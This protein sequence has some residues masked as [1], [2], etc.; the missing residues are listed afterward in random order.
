MIIVGWTILALAATYH[1][2]VGHWFARVV[3]FVALWPVALLL[4]D[5]EASLWMLPVW[6]AAAWAVASLPVWI[7]G[8]T[9]RADYSAVRLEV[10]TFPT[11]G[12]RR[13]R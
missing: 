6:L 4:A 3:M 8:L 5:A 7:K 13:V 11:L 9:T 2:L 10:R 12:Q 1:W